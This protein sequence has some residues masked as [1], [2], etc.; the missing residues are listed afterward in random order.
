MLKTLPYTPFIAANKT[1]T[2]ILILEINV[3][4][5]RNDMRR[6]CDKCDAVGLFG[7]VRSCLS[8]QP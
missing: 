2:L 7:V 1:R 3:V 4:K 6:I 8:T 5:C